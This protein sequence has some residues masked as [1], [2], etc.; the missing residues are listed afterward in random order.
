MRI[1]YWADSWWPAIGGI[2]VLGGQCVR[3]LR[4]E[5]F[6]VRVVTAHWD[7]SRPDVEVHEGIEIHR[8]PFPAALQG[9]RLDLF[10]RTLQSVRHL[11]RTW[12]PDILHLHFPSPSGLFHLL[13]A[14]AC[15][16]PLVLAMHTHVPDWNTGADTLSRRLLH[17]SAWVTA[18]SAAT[19]ELARAADDTISARSSV[20]HNGL[21]PPAVPPTRLDV[22]TPVVACAGRLVFK[23]GIDT[24]ITAM[25]RVRD[26]IPGVRLLVAGDGP[27]RSRL[28]R[29]ARD[30]NVDECVTFRGWVEP[31]TMSAFLNEATLL[32]VP[33]RTMEPF[34]NVAVEAMQMG[35][36][37][38]ATRL[39][40]LAEVVADGETGFLVDPDDPAAMAQRIIAL[41]SDP[42]GA[43]RMGEAGKARARR[44]FSLDRYVRDYARLYR[45]LG[46]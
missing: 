4:A 39:G 11:K 12:Q 7:E 19:M 45:E 6:D 30:L 36:P 41:V 9:R 16:A 3:R 38:V 17:R 8:F 46:G 1:L 18:N 43:E 2:E 25:V 27:E 23:K 29:Q 40:G 35:R 20:I 42:A 21:A 31:N 13:T 22:K 24:L 15:A 37:V 26:T 44:M 10:A 14:D 33:S 28:E 32:A 5:G 34:G